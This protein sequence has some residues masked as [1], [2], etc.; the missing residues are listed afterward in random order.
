[1]PTVPRPAPRLPRPAPRLPRPAPRLPRPAPRER[2]RG[3]AGWRGRGA[4]SGAEGVAACAALLLV[5]R[6]GDLGMAT[7]LAYRALTIDPA[8]AD[9]L[10]AWGAVL[11]ALARQ[12]A[13]VAAARGDVEPRPPPPPLPYKV[14]TSR[15]S[16]RTNWTHLVPSPPARRRRAAARVAPRG[17]DACWGGWGAQIEAEAVAAFKEAVTL[18]PAH[19]PSIRMLAT[20]HQR[21]QRPG[22]AESLYRAALALHPDR[23][24]LLWRLGFMGEA[25]GHAAAAAELYT[26]ALRADPGHLP[27]L[28][29]AAHFAHSQVRLS[30]APPARRPRAP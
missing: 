16:L 9:G 7:H 15:P 24:P 8:S 23:P 1:L 26:R 3:A 2:A 4:L 30:L 21:E 25:T 14:D 17:A 12:A 10:H 20:H 13:K 6:G 19:L 18:H 5:R 27:A 22:D 28:I 11:L 29:C